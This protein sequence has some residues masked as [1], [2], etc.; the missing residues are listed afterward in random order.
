MTRID[1]GVFESTVGEL[2]A[3]VSAMTIA[4][5][6][7]NGPWAADVF[8][9]RS[10][11]S[12]GF[13]SSPYSRHCL[14]I[15]ADPQCAVTVHAEPRSW[16]AI[17]GLQLSGTARQVTGTDPQAEILAAYFDKFPFARELV[18]PSD[19]AS[20]RPSTATPFVFEPTRIRLID[21]S[22]GFGARYAVDVQDGALVGDPFPDTP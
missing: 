20:A 10:D 9:A 17:Q 3:T 14:D 6:G 2:L 4:T 13:L 12:L 16:Q 7:P 8:F 22:L 1:I 15:E 11:W 21:N 19:P 5:H 18:S